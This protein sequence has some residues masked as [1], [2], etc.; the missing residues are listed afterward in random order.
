MSEAMS[1][2]YG[3]AVTA[4]DNYPPPLLKGRHICAR[5]SPHRC[6]GLRKTPLSGE[7]AMAPIVEVSSIAVRAEHRPLLSRYPFNISISETKHSNDLRNPSSSPL[8]DR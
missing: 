5:S 8:R 7:G 1:W 2:A 6:S 4:P 3:S